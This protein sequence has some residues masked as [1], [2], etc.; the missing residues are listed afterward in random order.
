VTLHA[1]FPTDLLPALSLLDQRLITRL[2]PAAQTSPGSSVG[3]TPASKPDVVFQTYPFPNH[4]TSGTYYVRSAHPAL[5]H[6][7]RGRPRAT[8][9]HA[10][11]TASAD[12]SGPS[13][14]V[15]TRAWNC[16]CPAFAFAALRGGGLEAET[17][18]ERTADVGKGHGDVE[19]HGHGHGHGHVA[20]DGRAR[21]PGHER[22]LDDGA[23][24]R[25]GGARRRGAPVCKHLL[26]CV[27]AERC[28]LLGGFVEGVE[29]RAGE[30]A[31]WAAGWG[32]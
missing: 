5:R 31:G 7:R 3:P 20:A 17:E 24:W 18:A 11:P 29:M 6:P 8:D 1:L 30:E 26:A 27:L 12:T 2:N 9:A 19:G 23:E 22:G 15:R 25:F 10:A 21:G 4:Q 16:T 13:Y 14:E 32:G 28:G